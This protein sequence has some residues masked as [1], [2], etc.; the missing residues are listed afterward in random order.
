MTI[1][2]AFFTYIRKNIK[3]YSKLVISFT[4]INILTVLGVGSAQ[5]KMTCHGNEQNFLDSS[6][7]S[8]PTDHGYFYEG[9]G[10]ATLLRSHFA[11]LQG[12]IRRVGN[13]QYS[14]TMDININGTNRFDESFEFRGTWNE[15]NINY[16]L[17]SG[18]GPD[19]VFNGHMNGELY[20]RGQL[21]N[22]SNNNIYIYLNFEPEN[23]GNLYISVGIPGFNGVGMQL[24]FN[25][26]LT[27][28][29]F[30]LNTL[31]E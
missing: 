9:G 26:K 7:Q 23:M 22:T 17:L 13:G 19:V 20:F 8:G 27:K 25:V 12:E 1:N 6:N 21:V 4:L 3:N 11:N 31:N 30:R 24:P 10:L 14:A 15:S 18:P 16:N 29:C 5:G 2:V 28:E